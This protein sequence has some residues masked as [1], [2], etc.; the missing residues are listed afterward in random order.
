MDVE[1]TSVLFEVAP[2]LLPVFKNTIVQRRQVSML[3]QN[4]FQIN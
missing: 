3:K 2:G 4:H 1:D